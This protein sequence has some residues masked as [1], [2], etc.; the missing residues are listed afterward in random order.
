MTLSQLSL[1][2]LAALM[3]SIATHYFTVRSK[4][5][6]ILYSERLPAYKA[7]QSAL[8]SLKKYCRACKHEMLANE[9][10]PQ[11]PDLKPDDKNTAL[12]HRIALTH[13][14]DDHGIFL[15]PS[16]RRAIEAVI[17]SGLDSICIFEL[18][19]ADDSGEEYYHKLLTSYEGGIRAVDKCMHILSREL[20]SFR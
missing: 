15:S 6:D 9:L 17:G 5:L 13:A 20:F 8:V 1:S 2:V 11:I 18:N 16:S 3:A 14:L 10:A 4:R 12:Q 7:A 19:E